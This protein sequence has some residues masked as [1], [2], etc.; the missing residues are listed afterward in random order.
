MTA[1]SNQNTVPAKFAI[2]AALTCAKPFMEFPY[3]GSAA[4]S[5]V[6]NCRRELLRDGSDVI[7]RAGIPLI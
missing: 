6:K 1:V 7:D 3:H 4:R 2:V 5:C